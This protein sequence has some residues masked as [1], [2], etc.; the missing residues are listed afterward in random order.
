MLLLF[1]VNFLLVLDL[2]LLEGLVVVPFL[3]LFCQLQHLVLRGIS[4]H[5]SRLLTTF[6]FE[7]LAL[8][9]L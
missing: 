1:E 7:N 5:L 6:S 8:S 9:I 2:A 4:K 3:F